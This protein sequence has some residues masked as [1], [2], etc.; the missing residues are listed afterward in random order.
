ME[1]NVS[2]QDQ[3]GYVNEKVKSLSLLIKNLKKDIDKQEIKPEVK[4]S[5]ENNICCFRVRLNMFYFQC[6]WY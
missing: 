5:I 1:N 6:F 4:K 2:G 3:E